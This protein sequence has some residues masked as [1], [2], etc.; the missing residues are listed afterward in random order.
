L[1]EGKENYFLSIQNRVSHDSGEVATIP[2]G[3]MKCDGSLIDKGP[4]KN[5]VTPNLNG[6]GRFLRG[7]TPLEMQDDAFQVSTGGWG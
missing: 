1:D 6:E 2:Y 4:W 5:F 7:G 3:W